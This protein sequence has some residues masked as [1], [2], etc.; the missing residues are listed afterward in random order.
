MHQNRLLVLF[1]LLSAFA[2]GN[3]AAEMK[4]TDGDSI[5]MD[6]VRIRLSG[7]DAPEY[8]QVCFD[9]RGE[10]Y[11]CGLKAREEL[12]RLIGGREVNCV[13]EKKDIY[14]R[15]LSTCYA[16]E[17]NLNQKM[18]EN[19]W[20]VAYKTDKEEYL[21]AEQNAKKNKRGVWQGKFMKPE[22]YRIWSKD[23]NF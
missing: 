12:V 21:A 20:A 16:G 14:K 7:I 18:L 17:V 3:V 9:Q 15:D 22:L 19:G 1:V 10:E 23:S 13:R 4:I 6:G 5:E 11:L 8:Q 2:A